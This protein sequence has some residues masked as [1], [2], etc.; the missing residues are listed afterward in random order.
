MINLNVHLPQMQMLILG[1]LGSRKHW[2]ARN[3][4]FIQHSHQ[5]AFCVLRCETVKNGPHCLLI[6]ASTIDGDETRVCKQMLS[7]YQFR[8]S[9]PYRL[10]HNDVEILLASTSSTHQNIP[11]LP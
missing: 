6:L 4:N 2:A 9:W 8:Q 11:E 10:L 1:Q 5:L 3:V 7:A